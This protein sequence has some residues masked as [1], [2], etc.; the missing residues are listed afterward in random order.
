MANSELKLGANAKIV[1]FL[2]SVA[3]ALVLFKQIK[4]SLALA[5]VLHE[6]KTAAS[7][8]F[9]LFFFV[10]KDK[11]FRSDNKGCFLYDRTIANC[12]VFFFQVFHVTT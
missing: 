8:Y 10:A 2:R 4:Q 9:F 12:F 6:L 11:F 5:F 3:L 1:F 7:H